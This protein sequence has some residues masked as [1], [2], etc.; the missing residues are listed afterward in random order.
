MT[1]SQRTG[2]HAAAAP[3]KP[4]AAGAVTAGAATAGLLFSITVPS[5][6]GSE[7]QIDASERIELA[8]KPVEETAAEFTVQTDGAKDFALDEVSVTAEA[9]VIEEPVVEEVVEEEVVEAPAET[10]VVEEAT[11][12][13][14]EEPAAPAAVAPAETAQTQVATTQQQVAAPAPAAPAPA[15]PAPAASSG[16][17][18][19]VVAVARSSAPRRIVRPRLDRRR[20]CSLLRGRPLRV[21]WNQPRRLG[22]RW[23]RQL[24]LR[25]VGRWRAPVQL[26]L[27]RCW[28]PDPCFAGT[29]R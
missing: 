28:H 3:I 8:E 1:K 7:E 10:T 11:P 2:R 29:A 20:S 22:L 12:A 25:P 19:T 6:V 5:A 18:S 15:A 26:R 17:G 4:M 23:L 16:T 9:P 14:T 21:G 13:V 24:R 27:P